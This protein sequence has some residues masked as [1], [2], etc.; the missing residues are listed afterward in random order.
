[1]VALA[2]V[3]D[4]ATRPRL[5]QY[6]RA[7]LR[8]ELYH[9]GRW[10]EYQAEHSGHPSCDT[11][12]RFLEGRGGGLG[13]HRVLCLDMPVEVWSTN[14]RVMALDEQS[15]AAI[16]TIYVDIVGVDGEVMTWE[17][18]AGR[19]HVSES[20]LRRLHNAALIRIAGL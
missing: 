17:R 9:W 3:V 13:G 10:M 15:R 7:A 4:I 16:T 11:V 6:D 5:D 19:I 14:G 1:M 8:R 2:E 18:R 20:T 12:T